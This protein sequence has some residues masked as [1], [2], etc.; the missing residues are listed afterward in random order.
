MALCSYNRVVAILLLFF[1]SYIKKAVSLFGNVVITIK[2]YV[3]IELLEK[4]YLELD[5]KL[6][7][8]SIGTNGVDCWFDTDRVRQHR[9]LSIEDFNLLIT[10]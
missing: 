4:Y 3:M 9:C 8:H 2:L 1:L 7:N 6:V 5:S 10:L